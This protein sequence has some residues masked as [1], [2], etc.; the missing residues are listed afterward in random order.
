LCIGIAIAG[1]NSVIVP[2]SIATGI[3]G[4]CLTAPDGTTHE[5]I[6]TY[7]QLV[8]SSLV[9]AIYFCWPAGD[10]WSGSL[11]PSNMASVSPTS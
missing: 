11:L 3:S 2:L 9:P 4:K 1:V 10:V 8:I 6:L 5:K 7:P